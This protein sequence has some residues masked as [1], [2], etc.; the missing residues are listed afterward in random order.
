MHAMLEANLSP[1]IYFIKTY[2]TTY[3]P[4]GAL[5]HRYPPEHL[6]GTKVAS[7]RPSQ[8]GQGRETSAVRHAPNINWISSSRDD[9]V[10]N[11]DTNTPPCI[12]VYDSAARLTPATR[13]ISMISITGAILRAL[14]HVAAGWPREPR[15]LRTGALRHPND[16]AEAKTLPRRPSSRLAGAVAAA[17]CT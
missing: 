7:R 12:P 9:I 13:A 15:Y 14:S 10:A 4:I 8:N 2:A 17:I 11:G 6:M 1:A 5:L 16:Y 3:A